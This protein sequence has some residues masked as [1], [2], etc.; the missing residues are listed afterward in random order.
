MVFPSL[1]QA[2]AE[3]LVRPPRSF[4]LITITDLD[5]RLLLMSQILQMSAI[6]PTHRLGT[7]RIVESADD[8][9]K[10][11]AFL[12]CQA[13]PLSAAVCPLRRLLVLR[14]REEEERRTLRS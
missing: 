14:T 11:F 8:V 10:R 13:T 1:L 9:R 7:Y 5:L 2:A 6:A 3:T 12:G 4:D